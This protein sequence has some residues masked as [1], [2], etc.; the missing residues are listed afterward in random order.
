MQNLD[1][2]VQLIKE[3]IKCFDDF[4]YANSEEFILREH[5]IYKLAIDLCVVD[6]EWFEA[7]SRN[8]SIERNYMLLHEIMFGEVFMNSNDKGT[9]KEY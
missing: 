7:R 4:D 9:L 2:L 3:D 1:Y 6:K 5:L 8:T